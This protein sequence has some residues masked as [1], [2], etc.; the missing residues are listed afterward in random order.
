MV[1]TVL[2]SFSFFP[3]RTAIYRSHY[4]P[5]PRLATSVTALNYRTP[6][7]PQD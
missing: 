1:G 4:A 7:S 2:G 5:F 3:T 6:G